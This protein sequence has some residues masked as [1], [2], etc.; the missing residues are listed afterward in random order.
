MRS[1]INKGFRDRSQVKCLF[2]SGN[3]WIT[4]SFSVDVHI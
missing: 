2:E 1:T 3:F 4:I